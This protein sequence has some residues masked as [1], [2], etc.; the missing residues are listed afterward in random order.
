MLCV[1]YSCVPLSG[2]A[3]QYCRMYLRWQVPW[4][5]LMVC[6]HTDLKGI[7][8]AYSNSAMLWYIADRVQYYKH[9]K[10]TVSHAISHCILKEKLNWLFPSLRP[11]L[12]RDVT[13]NQTQIIPI[14]ILQ[15]LLQYQSTTNTNNSNNYPPISLITSLQ[16]KHK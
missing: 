1:Q 5:H 6:V 15:F 4:P 14:I 12:C 3:S 2:G 9:Q 7:R 8:P 13:P 16:I 11:K 10:R